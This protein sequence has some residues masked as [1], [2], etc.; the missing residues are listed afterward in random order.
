MKCSLCRRTPPGWRCFA[1]LACLA[2]CATS[3]CGIDDDFSIVT[4][5]GNL[6]T[7]FQANGT[8]HCPSGFTSPGSS[9]LRNLTTS[10]ATV[11]TGGLAVSGPTVFSGATSLGGA[12]TSSGGIT[13]SS[14]GLKLQP[15]NTLQ[16]G[17]ATTLTGQLT[18]SGGITTTT[19]TTSG[20]ASIG[21]GG[22][23]LAVS[24]TSTFSSTATF[25]GALVAASCGCASFSGEAAPQPTIYHST[26]PSA[27]FQSSSNVVGDHT[28]TGEYLSFTPTWTGRYR[29][30]MRQLISSV[31]GLAQNVRIGLSTSSTDLKPAVPMVLRD[32]VTVWSTTVGECYVPLDAGSTYTWYVMVGAL[33]GSLS[34]TTIANAVGDS[35]YYSNVYVVAA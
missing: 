20:L 24:G 21:S 1:F 32:V 19:L 5:A 18:A 31:S 10:S 23:A 2:S 35:R 34:G 28:W 13:V 14:G 8:C 7:I 6:F 33:G 27:R 12:V 17:G 3:Q 4:P 29:V 25:S 9:S 15:G 22:A 30:H 11:G 16:V 26:Q